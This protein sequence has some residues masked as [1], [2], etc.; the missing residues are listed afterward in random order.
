[1]VELKYRL[2]SLV[3]IRGVCAE[4]LPT[5]ACVA[6]QCPTRPS[7]AD[8]QQLGR[9]ADAKIC[10]QATHLQLAEVVH[11]CWQPPAHRVMPQQLR[12]TSS[13]ATQGQVAPLLRTSWACGPLRVVAVQ[14]GTSIAKTACF[15]CLTQATGIR[16]RDWKRILRKNGYLGVE[17]IFDRAAPRIFDCDC[18]AM[19]PKS[20][21]T[22]HLLFHSARN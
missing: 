11:L 19:M 9:C 12:P 1:M 5:F 18:Q 14:H 8:T 7:T 3:T 10:R 4:R 6:L 20:R 17:H 21:H 15:V 13:I 2:R 16:T 22:C